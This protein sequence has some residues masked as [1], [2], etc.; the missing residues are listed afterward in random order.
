MFIHLL[1]IKHCLVCRHTVRETGLVNVYS[2]I[3]Y[4]TLFSLSS[5]CKRNRIS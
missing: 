3:G 2:L 5:H 4:K 1:V